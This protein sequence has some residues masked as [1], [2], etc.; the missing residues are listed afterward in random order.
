MVPVRKA[1]V[2]KIDFGNNGAEITLKDDTMTEMG[3]YHAAGNIP[4]DPLSRKIREAR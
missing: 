2:K 4:R 3:R 1:S